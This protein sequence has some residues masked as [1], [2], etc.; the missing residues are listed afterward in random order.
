MAAVMG[1]LP[2]VPALSR[3]DLLA[4]PVVT[5]L[6]GWPRA[7]EVKVAEIDPDLAD[8]AAFCAAYQVPPE[9]SANCV[10]VAGKREG[11]V[12]YAACLVLAT[13][14]ASIDVPSRDRKVRPPWE[15]RWPHALS[16]DDVVSCSE[17]RR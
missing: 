15:E 2:T 16:G 4:E 11:Q 8:T 13:N 1:T 7:D 3:P 17:P 6:R 9:I 10:V 12:R 5:A 14:R